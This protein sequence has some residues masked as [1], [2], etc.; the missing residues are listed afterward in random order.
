MTRRPTTPLRR[1]RLQLTGWY[2][3]VFAL[4]LILLGAGLFLTIRNQMSRRLD[5]SLAAAAAALER[6]ER[7]REAERTSAR[8]AVVDAVEE[9]HIPERSLYLLDGDAAPLTPPEVADWIRDAARGVVRSGRGYKNLDAPDHRELRLYAERFT[10]ASGAPYIAAVMADRGELEDEYASLIEAFAVAALAGL[11][12]IAGGGYVLVRKSTAPAERSMDQMRRFMADAAHELRTPIT[13]LRTRAEVALAQPRDPERDAATLAA[14]ERETARL[15]GIAG[16]LLT[17][18]RADA[19]DRPLGRERLY[20]DDAAAGAVD[21]AQ[22]LAHAKRV[23]LAVGSFDEAPVIG[24]PDLIRRLLLIVLDNAV[25]FTPAGGD[26]RLDVSTTDGQATAVVSDTGIGIAPEQL[27]HVF[28]RFYRG[29]PAR[30]Q[31]DGAGLGLAIARWIADAHGARIDIAS[32]PGAGTRVSI[33][34]P[35]AA[36]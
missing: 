10:G 16:D 31:A 17:L 18:A 28:E 36:S 7:I 29:D 12:L 4:V 23:T 9:L 33:M 13:V 35:V 19:G 20:L 25:K 5:G 3:G 32:E 15:G 8:G 24:D 22:A 26:V 11:A 2:A 1:L 27:P 21:A 34:F 14:I 30:R 6:A